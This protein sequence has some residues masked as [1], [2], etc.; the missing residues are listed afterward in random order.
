MND[1]TLAGLIVTSPTAAFAELKER[2][3]FVF[4]LITL[5]LASAALMFWYYSVVDFEWLKEHLFSANPRVQGMTPEQRDRMFKMMSQRTMVSSGVAGAAIGLPMVLALQ[6]GYYWL[7]GRVTNVTHTFT[8]WFALVCWA[9]LPTLA[10]VVTSMA[11]LA[12][13]SAPVQVGPSELQLLSINEL[14][15][16]RQ[17]GELGYTLLSSMNLLSLWTWGL[18][19]LGVRTWTSRSWLFSAVFVMLPFVVVYGCWTFFAFKG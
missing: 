10:G 5:I 4:P 17:P 19:I 7:A 18:T 13:H 1:I 2:P 6:A 14:F 16:Q 3:R 12:T 15:F 9:G 11:M 8:Q